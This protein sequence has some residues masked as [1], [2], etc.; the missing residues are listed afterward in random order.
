M[1]TTLLLAVPLLLG[2]CATYYEKPGGTPGEFELA[3]AECRMGAARIRDEF[4]WAEYY[5]ACL[6][7]KGWRVSRN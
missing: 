6:I 5:R 7:T 1:R 3:D 4:R 2:G